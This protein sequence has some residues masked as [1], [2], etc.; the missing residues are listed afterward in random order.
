MGAGVVRVHGTGKAL[1]FTSDVTPRYVMANP[2]EGGKQAVAEAWRNITAVGG[3]PLA[4]TDNLNFGNPEKP[5]T[6]GVIVKAIEGMAEA[7]RVLEFP[8]VSGNVSL[9]NE[10]DG[11]GIP[12]TPVVGGIGLIDNLDH[13]ATLK[14][15][16]PGDTLLVIGETTGHLG[17]SAY[18]RTILGLDGPAA[19]IAPRVNLATEAKHAAIIRKLIAAGLVNAVHDVSDGGIACAAAEMALASGVGVTFVPDREPGDE[20]AAPG[21]FGEDQARYLVAVSD[22]QNARWGVTGTVPSA[23]GHFGGDAVVIQTGWGADQVSHVVP[24]VKLRA[25]YEGWLPGYMNSAG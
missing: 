22:T 9:Y 21:L 12:P 15:A 5:D 23:I 2:F 6:M 8:V 24:L 10:T 14:G 11:V 20:L 18:A 3:R 1:A 7:C 17:A 16:Q 19:G 4:I 13:I 25:A